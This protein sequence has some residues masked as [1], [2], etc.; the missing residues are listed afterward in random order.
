MI[1]QIKLS[2][3]TMEYYS[4]IKLNKPLVHAAT[5]MNFETLCYTKE[6]SHH[7]LHIIRSGSYEMPRA[8]KSVE[9]LPGLS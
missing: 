8:V 2:V 4:P 9:R 3:Y 5:W 7:I 6:A 1:G